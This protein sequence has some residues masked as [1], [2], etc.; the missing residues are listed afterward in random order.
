MIL[1]NDYTSYTSND[2]VEALDYAI[3][4]LKS[5]DIENILVPHIEAEHN[6]NVLRDIKQ[7]YDIVNLAK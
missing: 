4:T 2:Y 3:D 5:L 6:I 7:I 1:M